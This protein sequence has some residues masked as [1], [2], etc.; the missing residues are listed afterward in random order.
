MKFAK[1]SHKRNFIS[2]KYFE[3]VK[4]NFIKFEKLYT[5]MFFSLLQL[6]Y[7]KVLYVVILLR[8]AKKSGILCIF[9][10]V[11]CENATKIFK[12]LQSKKVLVSKVFPFDQTT[13]ISVCEIF[14]L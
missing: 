1:I 10:T 2:A 3:I 6:L 5:H 14:L 7:K 11:V 8:K 13:K 4:K 9:F 12:I